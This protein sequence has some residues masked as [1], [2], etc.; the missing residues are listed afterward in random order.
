M[1]FG[2]NIKESIDDL[3]LHHELVPMILYAET[4]Y[5]SVSDGVNFHLSLY[6]LQYLLII[7]FIKTILSDLRKKG[8]SITVGID[9]TQ[10][11]GISRGKDGFVY[12]N[13]DNREGGEA[14]G[15]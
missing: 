1:W 11:H 2:E 5:P 14:A 4:N 12:A 8:H 6:F 15:F 7:N 9:K 10:S 13:A 3:R